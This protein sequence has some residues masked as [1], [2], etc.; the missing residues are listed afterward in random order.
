MITLPITYYEK[1]LDIN[2][3]ISGEVTAQDLFDKLSEILNP[4]VNFSRFSLRIYNKQ[5]DKMEWFSKA[6]GIKISRKV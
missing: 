4:I 6:T 1:L 2:R 3:A 5:N